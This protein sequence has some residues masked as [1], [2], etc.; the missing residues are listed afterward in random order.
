MRSLMKSSAS[1]YRGFL[2]VFR[3]SLDRRDPIKVS[4]T[5][6]AL[7]GSSR[8]RWSTDM[9][10]FWDTLGIKPT[11]DTKKIRKAYSALVKIH[12]PEDDEEEFRKINGA[13]KAAMKFAANFERLD[14][15][16]EQIQ[17]TDVRPDGSFGVKFFD[18]D[19]KPLFP[20]PPKTPPDKDPSFEPKK[21]EEPLKEDDVTS[22]DCI[23]S[24]V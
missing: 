23:D 5:Y 12:N 1:H 10:I 6:K 4:R 11:T 8:L 13:Y 14:V 18:K 16:D 3:A 19:G 20:E 7:S 17:I 21:E 2:M 22:C 24:S 15:S 9:E